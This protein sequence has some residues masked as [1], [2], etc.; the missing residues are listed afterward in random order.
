MSWL[1]SKLEDKD[2]EVRIAASTPLRSSRLHIACD[3]YPAAGRT[4]ERSGN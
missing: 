3:S 2:V 1:E 4:G